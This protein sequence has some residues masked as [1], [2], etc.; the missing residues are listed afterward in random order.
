MPALRF[1]PLGRRSVLLAPE[2]AQRGVPDLPPDEPDPAPCDF[3]PGR[4]DRTPPE[5]AAARE[6]G[7]E[8]DSPGWRVRAFANLYPATTVHEVVVHTP[9]H[10]TR[11]ED[12]TAAHR[13][14]VLGTYRDRLA[15]VG[16]P[17]AL[18]S[19]NRGRGAGASRTHA[20]GQIFG[21]KV[22]PPTVQRET[23]AF[24]SPNCEL[25]RLAGDAPPVLDHGAV[26]VVAHPV[27]LV[28]HELLV[29]PQCRPRFDAEG[30]DSLADAAEAL[31]GALRRLRA[32]FG[33]NLPMNVVFHT[34]P[35][36]LP[37]FH[38]HAHVMPRLAVWGALEL[39]AELPIVAADPAVTA[40]MLR[41]E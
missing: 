36:S 24:T 23:V 6:P 1:D 2:R 32:A 15:A 35:G 18:F 21:L 39:G 22:I 16:L 38:W 3:C 8:P 33:A 5:T 31:A 11:F 40:D 20:H 37:R 9:D 28:A 25:C 34:A 10:L 17:C 41:G 26:R 27:P 14:E 13:L 7:T 12:L 29:V 30:D 19:F 4:E